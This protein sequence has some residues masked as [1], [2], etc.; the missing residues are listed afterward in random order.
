LVLSKIERVLSN[1]QEPQEQ[2]E[3]DEKISIDNWAT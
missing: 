3:N 1:E 2:E